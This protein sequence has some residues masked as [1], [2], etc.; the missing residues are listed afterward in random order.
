MI[1]VLTW[2]CQNG[3]PDKPLE[4]AAGT[5]VGPRGRHAAVVADG[6]SRT[7]QP[8]GKYPYPSVASMAAE[9]VAETLCEAF[10]TISLVDDRIDRALN[11]VNVAVQQLSKQW[12]L[13]DTCDYWENDLPGAVFSAV[14][15]SSV[16]Q[17]FLWMFLTDCG[18]AQLESDGQVV[19]ITPDLLAPVRVRFPTEEQAG[20]KKERQR[21]IRRDFRNQPDHNLDLSFG[22]LTGE[23]AAPAYVQMGQRQY[24]RGQT[25][26]LFSDG[27][28]PFFA[29]RF[30]RK[31]LCGGTTAEL[32]QWI[33]RTSLDQDKDDKTLVII[34]T[35]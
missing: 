27:C 13:W 15:V 12:G 14:I 20:G 30:F 5:A 23:P 22:V 7:R 25:I 32:D 31:I 17:N 1:T 8:D 11:R 35:V 10:R 19:W 3:H 4:D 21:S 26:V 33:D 29:D 2:Q 6:V 34:R 16:S 28:R 24:S 18:V 9:I